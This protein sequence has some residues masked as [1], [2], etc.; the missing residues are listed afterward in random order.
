M[1]FPGETKEEFQRSCD[2]A[3]RV[4]FYEAHVFKYS[5]RRGT[6]ADRMPDQIPETLK[7]ERSEE[8]IRITD[9][10]SHEFRSYYLG[11]E[12]AFLS[13]ELITIGGESYETGFTP[14]YVRCIKKTETLH[15]NDI[16][17]GKVSQIVQQ[18][19]IDESLVLV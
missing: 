1:G 19:V 8:L 18:N 2:F 14:E 4:G 7:A 12:A 16:L 11:K 13:E 3:E 15:S 10:L 5:R 6:V 17:V 9:R